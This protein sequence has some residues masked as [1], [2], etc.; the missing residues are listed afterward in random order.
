V[1]V[2]IRFGEDVNSFL[3]KQCQSLYV[4]SS[5]KADYRRNLSA[6]GVR[7]FFCFI[8]TEEKLVEFR[9]DVISVRVKC[10]TFIQVPSQVVHR[11]DIADWGDSCGNVQLD[12]FG[13]FNLD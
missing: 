6:G 9:G 8:D 13:V 3:L 7:K 11:N 2:L 1:S 4:F 5:S 10:K 12:V